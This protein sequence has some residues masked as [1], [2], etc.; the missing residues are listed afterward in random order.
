MSYRG[1]YQT[2]SAVTLRAV[3]SDV[4]G[5]FMSADTDPV[6]YFYDSSVSDS[7]RS[8]EVEAKTFTSAIASVTASELSTGYYSASW[9]VSAAEGLVY[10]YWLGTI[11]GAQQ[12]DS[13]TWTVT[14]GATVTSQAP[15][16]NTM[17]ILE[18][19]G[20]T[21]TEGNSLT[22]E[23]FYTTVYSPMYASPDMLKV[24]LGRWIDY[25]PDDTLA[26]MLHLSS[27]TADYVTPPGVC[28]NQNRLKYAR[29]MFVLFDAAIRAMTIPGHGQ[30]SN[31]VSGGRKSLGDLS[32]SL[33]SNSTSDDI[34]D[35]IGRLKVMRDQWYRVLQSG[36]CTNP[37]QG[38]APAFAVKGA[39]DPDRRNVG[40]LWEDP[41][42]YHYA[43]PS[44]NAKVRHSGR[45]RARWGN[46][47]NINTGGPRSMPI[48]YLKYPINKH[49]VD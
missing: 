11:D 46:Y 26:L 31:S 24:E 10:E 41:D 30:S 23:L 3:F 34:E 33:G 36:G 19:D 42:L 29:T 9:T 48:R 43:D 2:G 14:A 40:R 39:Y 21:D 22:T 18:I 6:V 45:R 4:N 32:I 12:V 49:D 35:T 13:F 44:V 15:G 20:I 25:I 16:K 37:G 5:N 8:A 7:V 28:G 47:P 1:A 17:V 38:Y 27:K